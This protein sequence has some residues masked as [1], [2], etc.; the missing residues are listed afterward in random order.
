MMSEN[1]EQGTNLYVSLNVSFVFAHSNFVA[2]TAVALNHLSCCL[3]PF[4][5]QALLPMY[6][7]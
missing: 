1:S 3:S 6:A 5:M 4:C 7:S 2:K